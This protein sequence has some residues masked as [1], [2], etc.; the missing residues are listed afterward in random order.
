MPTLVIGV[1][2]TWDATTSVDLVRG[3]LERG[4]LMTG[5]LGGLVLEAETQRPLPFEVDVQGP[6][7]RLR[8]AFEAVSGGQLSKAVLSKIARHTMTLYAVTYEP[9]SAELCLQVMRFANLLLELGGLAVKVDT[10]GVAHSAQR[11]REL[12]TLEMPELAA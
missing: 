4:Y 3:L 12:L 1:P 2:G 10:A 9:P 11:W 6:D 7:P 8:S 5:G